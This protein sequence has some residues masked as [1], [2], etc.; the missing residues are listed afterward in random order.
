MNFRTIADT[1]S[2]RIVE[3]GVFDASPTRRLSSYHCGQCGITVH[4]DKVSKEA[5]E[6]ACSGGIDTYMQA[7]RRFSLLDSLN[8]V[9]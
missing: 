2:S 3:D 4:P 1:N 6:T 8:V 5:L 7:S 9:I